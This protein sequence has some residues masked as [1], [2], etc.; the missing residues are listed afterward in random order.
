VKPGRDG[1]AGLGLLIGFAVATLCP[2]AAAAQTADELIAKNL[3]ARGGLEKLR[4]IQSMRLTGTLTVGESTMPSVLEVKRPNKTRWEFTVNGQTA[5]Q[6][7]DGKEAWAVAPFAGQTEPEPMSTEDAKDVALQA[8]MDGPLVD[9]RAKGHRVE[10]MGLEK[11]GG[12]D[13]WRLK[14]ILH[15]GD[16]RDLYL[17]LK[18]HLQ[19]AS[20]ARRTVR[21][22]PVEVE[23][24]LGDYREVGGVLLPHSF[25][26]RVKGVR[27]TQSVRFDK[28]E[29][30]VP[31]DDSRFSRPPVKE[32]SRVPQPAPTP[33]ARP[34][35]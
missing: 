8:D 26:T 12:R 5:V 22:R 3:E 10:L 31:I 34:V 19:I 6:A 35:S 11:V 30:N 7:Y 16:V 32:P 18:T 23:S 24:E 14:V 13:A 28:I 1:S 2:A 20:I 17:D 15:D 27:E 9:Y 21:G 25:E 29:L 4:A 33:A